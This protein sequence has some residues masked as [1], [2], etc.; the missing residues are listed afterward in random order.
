[1]TV[2]RWIIPAL[3]LVF[4]VY[5]AISA[6]G[7]K[8]S[9]RGTAWWKQ[10]ALRLAIIA[11]VIIIVS[12]PNVHRALRL[13]QAH[14]SGPFAGAIGTALVGLGFGLAISARVNLG[15]NWGTPMSR[16]ENPELVSGGP[17]AFI[18]HPIYAGILLAMLGS[19][20]GENLV[21]ALVLIPFGAYFFYTARREEALMTEQFPAEYRAYQQRT[22]M[23]VPFVL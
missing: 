15:R 5:W 14:L 6:I 3:W 12:I 10:A 8:R 19:A 18:R 4:L 2:L 16:K 20:I 11:V 21:F 22:K 13:A 23:F 9:I 1:M 7:V 17:Y